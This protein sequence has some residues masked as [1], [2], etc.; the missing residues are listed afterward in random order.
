MSRIEVIV[1]ELGRMKY[2]DAWEYQTLLHNSLKDVKI[3]NRNKDD[4]DKIMQNHYFLFVEHPH[5]YTLGKSGTED[6][7]LID[8]EKRETE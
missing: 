3:A 6:H 4:A 5:V 2:K 7:L 1:K 8:A